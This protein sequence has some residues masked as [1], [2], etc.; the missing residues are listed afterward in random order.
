MKLLVICGP[1]ATGKT[2]LGIYLARKFHGEIISA[3]SRQVY[4]KMD[5]I[6][7]KDI[8]KNSKF[9]PPAGGPNSK[10]GIESN[11]KLLVGY[12]LKNEIPIW[13]V[14]IA[15]IEY[16][17]NV[18]EYTK[19]ATRVIEDISS[20]E[21]LPVIVGGTG[22][23]IKSLLYPLQMITIAPNKKLRN[24]LSK[25]DR[26]GLKKY[27]QKI[28]PRKWN[29]MNHSD[30]MNP[31]RLIRAI[32]ISLNTKPSSTFDINT[33]QD[34]SNNKDALIIGLTLPKEKLNQRIDERIKKRMKEGVLEE[35][36]K[37]LQKKPSYNLPSLSSTG[38][39]QLKNY[40][41]GKVSLSDAIL[42]WQNAEHAFAKRQLTW[43]KTMKVIYWYDVS[44]K[45]YLKKIEQK[46]E[47]WYT[48]TRLA[49]SQ[50]N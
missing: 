21:N 45:N 3:D 14:D 44:Q 10:L 46:V 11:N 32:E 16:I 41:D 31:R 1:T 40:L 23:Y 35:A 9:H 50:G 34:L 5:I 6:T 28:N 42:Q 43:F 12:R 17:F 36:Q 22:L 18:G 20:R 30:R 27:L 29:S 13:L 33:K 19:I 24:Q 26:E 39:Q 37:I 38:F 49:N 2:D 15:G 8:D 4:Q 47:R 7:G 25:L 48:G